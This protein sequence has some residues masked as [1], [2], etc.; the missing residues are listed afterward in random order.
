MQKKRRNTFAGE[1]YE[2]D[3]V[4]ILNEIEV[5][6]K[7]LSTKKLRPDLDRSK[8]DI[9]PV[10]EVD[11][12]EFKYRIQ[13]KSSTKHVNYADLLSKVGKIHESDVQVILHK[14]TKRVAEDRFITTGTYAIL[15]QDNFLNLIA[16]LERYKL[17]YAEV[18]TFWD[19]IPD[20]QQPEL[21]KFLSSI[22]L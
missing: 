16:D 4:D 6:P 2:K 5:F 20:E 14:K 3:L 11:A 21:H 13:A 9:Y 19:S 8:I 22:G 17:G 15:S 1:A 7:V 12:K 10:E 18:M